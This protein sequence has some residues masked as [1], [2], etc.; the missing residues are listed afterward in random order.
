M[1]GG[2][3]LYSKGFCPFTQMARIALTASSV[4]HEFTRYQPQESFPDW[5]KTASPDGTFPVLQLPD[6]SYTNSSAK[7]IVIASEAKG[8]DAPSLYPEDRVEDVKTWE[9]KVRPGLV[10]PALKVL[11]AA[12]PDIQAEFRPKLKE[13]LALVTE[14]LKSRPEVTYF[15]GTQTPTSVDAIVY[16]V[17][18]RLP[19]IA[20][21]RG[22]TFSNDTIDAYVRF[23]ESN[24]SFTSTS[25]D[26]QQMKQFFIK[27]LPKMK[28][29]SMGRLQHMA[30]RRHYDKA[31]QLHK[32]L[33]GLGDGEEERAKEIA[34]E[35]T[36]R[37]TTLV[38]LIQT[39]ASF[40]EEV[41]YPVFEEMT[42]GSTSRAHSEHTHD[43]AVLAKFDKDYKAALE[44][45]L[46]PP[47]NGTTSATAAAAAEPE[48]K[49][50]VGVVQRA[51]KVFGAVAG[52]LRNLGKST[53]NQ[54]SSASLESSSSSVRSAPQIEV[55]STV[56]TTVKK[57]YGAFLD[58]LEHWK[59]EMDEHMAGE[60]KDLFPM[61][62]Q[63]GDKEIGVFT[64][65]YH[66]TSPSL[67]VLLPFI[68][69][70]LTPQER[71]QYMHNIS[72]ALAEKEPTE[73]QKVGGYLKS[74]L[75][76]GDVTD[77]KER[78][79]ALAPVVE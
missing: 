26:M 24:T 29:M 18:Q 58:G 37:V 78:L 62:A 11:M 59:K 17:L 12:N 65:I 21:F 36:R 74:G 66:H 1:S 41:V 77:L 16:P 31:L 8:A 73:W 35:L 67:E 53:S 42:P 46:A 20:Y 75:S 72:L 76:A 38:L 61:T 23:L 15:L 39:H 9:A 25:Y 55:G 56:V 32:E 52:S 71:M 63:L 60:E 68:L 28:P 7:M 5:W 10:Q 69:E 30:I 27:T 3:H 64:K 19:L 22:V 54:G 13:A 47:A 48:A 70:P 45:V 49:S 33:E 6:G 50:K 43:V 4:P 79:P 2:Y 14:Q 34:K 44:V 51:K 40:E 57:E